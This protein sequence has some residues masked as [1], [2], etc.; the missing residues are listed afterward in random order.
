[1][2][3]LTA[4]INMDDLVPRALGCCP[5]SAVRTG[6]GSASGSSRPASTERS[7]LT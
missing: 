7:Y 5:S 1:M 4:T 6:H 2:L 3:T